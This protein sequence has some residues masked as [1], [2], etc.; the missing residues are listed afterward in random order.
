M[1]KLTIPRIVA[2]S[3]EMNTVCFSTSVRRKKRDFPELRRFAAGL[4]ALQLR[5]CNRQKYTKNKKNI[6]EG[7]AL[8]CYLHLGHEEVFQQF[9]SFGRKMP[10][11]Q[12]GLTL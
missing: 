7:I 2:T 1:M 5:R 11:I 6:K 12:V 3:Q 10:R 9:S 4:F 8:L